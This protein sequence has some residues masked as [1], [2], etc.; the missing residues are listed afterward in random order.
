MSPENVERGR[1]LRLAK[2]IFAS[3]RGRSVTILFV[4]MCLKTPAERLWLSQTC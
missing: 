1:R 4:P 2:N 3:F